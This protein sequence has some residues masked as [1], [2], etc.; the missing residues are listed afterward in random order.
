MR[1]GGQ[2]AFVEEK[3]STGRGEL[4]LHGVSSKTIDMI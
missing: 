1:I 2:K 4:V 3:L